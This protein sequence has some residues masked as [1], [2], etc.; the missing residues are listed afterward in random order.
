MGHCSGLLSFYVNYDSERE[1]KMKKPLVQGIKQGVNKSE[2]VY[3]VCVYMCM[4][5]S[6]VRIMN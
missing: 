4:H 2:K 6:F 3:V 1:S 5:F